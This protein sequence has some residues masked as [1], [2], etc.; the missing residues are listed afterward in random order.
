ME[1]LGDVGH[2]EFHFG[3]FGDAVMS[4]QD[5]CMVCVKRTV[6]S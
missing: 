2:V 3:P 4:V 5:R 6:G 1:N